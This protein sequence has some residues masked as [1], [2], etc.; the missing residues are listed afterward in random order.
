M[1]LN[2]T[3]TIFLSSKIKGGVS[4]PL[5]L[6]LLERRIVMRKAFIGILLFAVMTIGC[7]AKISKITAYG[8][9]FK[10]DMINCDGSISHSWIS[11][12][13]VLSEQG[14]DGYYFTDSKSGKLLEVTGR[15]IITQIE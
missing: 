3:L 6:W 8:G 11:N 4:A 15:L 12:G 13:K 14:S 9:K 1:P 7:S 5:F 2:N 10:V